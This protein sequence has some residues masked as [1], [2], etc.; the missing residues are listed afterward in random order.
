MTVE[1]AIVCPRIGDMIESAIPEEEKEK[2]NSEIRARTLE[3]L[4]FKIEN[5]MY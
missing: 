5:N 3:H 4:R 2:R 1:K